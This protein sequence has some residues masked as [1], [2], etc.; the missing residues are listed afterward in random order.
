MATETRYITPDDTNCDYTDDI[1][2]MYSVIY[3]VRSITMAHFLLI[4]EPAIS[5]RRY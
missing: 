3:G 5:G 1:H 4:V 2:I